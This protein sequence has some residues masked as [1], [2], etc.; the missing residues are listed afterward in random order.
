MKLLKLSLIK[1]V[2][3]CFLF[4][5]STTLLSNQ[6]IEQHS[7]PPEGSEV[8]SDDSDIRQNFVSDGSRFVIDSLGISVAPPSGWDVS[9]GEMGL[10]IL[11]EAPKLSKIERKE[12]Q[13]KKEPTYRKNITI[14]AMHSAAPIDAKEAGILTEKI[15]SEFSKLAGVEN[16][17]TQGPVSFFNYKK[18]DDGMILY[19]SFVMNDIPMSQM[20]VIVSGEGNR[21]LL[22]YTDMTS[23][24]QSDEESFAK[25]WETISTI[26]VDGDAP[27]RYEDLKLYGSI[28]LGVLIF[29]SILLIIKR[30]RSLEKY[31]NI[32]DEDLEL[33]SSTG[34]DIESGKS[35]IWNLDSTIGDKVELKDD[36][37]SQP[38]SFISAF[39]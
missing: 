24:F 33:E 19:T 39:H 5:N 35:A 30:K 18:K 3:Y 8:A 28:G 34:S 26:E 11:I 7:P 38:S 25:A 23:T 16:Y 20:H 32:A 6:A 31:K 2:T 4:L 12:K 13:K 27:I 14:A 37:S 10:S 36:V 17:E 15:V 22:T 29:F 9:T 1:N 21:F